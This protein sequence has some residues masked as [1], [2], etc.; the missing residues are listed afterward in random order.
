MGPINGDSRN[1]V[2]EINA[3]TGLYSSLSRNM[4]S[5]ADKFKEPIL[6]LNNFNAGPSTIQVVTQQEMQKTLTPTKNNRELN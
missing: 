5:L 6:K 3:A 2:Q 4:K 1:R